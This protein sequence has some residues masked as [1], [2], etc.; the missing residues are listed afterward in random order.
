MVNSG[1]NS[2]LSSITAVICI[3]LYATALVYGASRIIIDSRNRSTIAEKEF[4]DISDRVSSAAVLGF[5]STPYQ[6]AVRDSILDSKTILAVIITGSNGEYGIERQPGTI[7]IWSGNSARFKT[8]FGISHTP[9]FQSVWIEGQRNATVKAIYSYLDYDLLIKVLRETLI[10]VFIIMALAIFVLLLD[11]NLKSL[12]ARAAS[13]EP[14][15]SDRDTAED[16]FDSEESNAGS[17]IEDYSKDYSE[18]FA[19]DRHEESAAA[20]DFT[21]NDY[22]AND[23]AES[24]ADSP[25][26]K[27]EIYPK[28]LYSPMGIG[29]ESYTRERLES[30]LHRCASQE[31]DLVFLM[32]SA[33]ESKSGK[34]QFKKL[35][36]E[37][38]GFFTLPDMIFE[39]GDTDLSLIIPT[40]NIDRGFKKSEEF[41]QKIAAGFKDNDGNPV[42]LRIGLSS[43]AGR[44]VEADRL[45]MEAAQALSKAREDPQAFVVAFKSDAE[46][47]RE[48]ISKK[49]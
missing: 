13:D 22:A 35:I 16:N 38:S 28:G 39:K 20:N 4:K 10:F 1:K 24:P 43:R 40:L 34:E 47:Y 27:N 31:E 6:N 9:F 33:A 17:D 46:K 18:D 32:I 12:A 15:P 14:A 5:M 41:R 7:I 36:K 2:L 42:N 49:I 29:W 26:E 25:A 21:A 23:Y 11:I 45:M 8:G 48:Y 19:E 44:L 30:E 3:I 37:C